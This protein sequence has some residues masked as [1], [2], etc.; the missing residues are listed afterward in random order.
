M[1]PNNDE[2]NKRRASRDKRR[3]EQKKRQAKQWGAVGAIALVLIIGIVAVIFSISHLQE[4]KPEQTTPPLQTQDTAGSSPEAQDTSVIHI[5]AGGDVNITDKVISAGL[6]EMGYDF[7]PMF[8]DLLPV[9]ADSDLTILNFEGVLYGNT[10]GTATA[11]APRE[12]LQALD[13]AGVDMLQTANSFSVASGV[14]SLK[15][16]ISSIRENGMEPVGTFAD[17]KSFQESGGFTF[18]NVGGIRVAVVAF[19][20]GVGGMGLPEGSEDCVNLLYTDYHGTYQKVD[21]EGITQVLK[22]VQKAQPDIT[23]ALLHWGSEYNDQISKTQDTIRNLMLEN[24]VDAIIGTHPH[25]VQKMVFDETTGAFT[26]Y[27][28]G[29]F[30]GDGARGGTEYSVLLDLEVTRNNVTGETRITGYDYTPIFL[31]DETAS[32]GSLRLL[33]IREAMAAYEQNAVGKVSQEIYNKMKNALERADARV[34]G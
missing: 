17:S 31:L 27:S 26:A 13:Q 7:T 9:L 8:T 33:R 23:I 24:S 25:H 29:D 20:K 4:N 11:A 15:Q 6:T 30:L 19:T 12:L 5:T 32:G 16:T 1:A 21:T 2:L 3:Q 10:Y 14:A 18:W 28:L 34:K 22:K